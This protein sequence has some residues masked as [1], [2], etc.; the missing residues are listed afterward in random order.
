MKLL[1]NL[2]PAR[3]GEAAVALLRWRASLRFDT[4]RCFPTELR[5]QIILDRGGGEYP[6]SE[7]VAPSPG[8]KRHAARE[9]LREPGQDIV[10]PPLIPQPGEGDFLDGAVDLVGPGDEAG[11][12]DG[13]EH[14]CVPVGVRS[15]AGA[16]KPAARTAR[17]L[18]TSTNSGGSKPRPH[19]TPSTA[20]TRCRVA[21]PQ[22]W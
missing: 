19:S 22:P 18:M 5:R 20:R 13:Q 2:L 14:A 3:P 6:E 16:R 8:D 9:L 4:P 7:L 10:P 15:K 17:R 12:T 21:L 11:G 1:G